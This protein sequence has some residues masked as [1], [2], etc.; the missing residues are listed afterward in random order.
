MR[1]DGVAGVKDVIDDADRV[2]AG[3]AFERLH[4]L[5]VRVHDEGAA[6]VKPVS[7]KI[8]RVVTGR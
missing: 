1:R 6:V 7:P 4:G 3:D 5:I 2:D 8:M